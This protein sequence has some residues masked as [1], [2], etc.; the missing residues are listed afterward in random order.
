MRAHDDP[1]DDGHVDAGALHRR[2]D[3]QGRWR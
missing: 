2:C 1:L 3:G